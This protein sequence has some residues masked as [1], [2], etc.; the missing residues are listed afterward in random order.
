[1]VSV[2]ILFHGDALLDRLADDGRSGGSCRRKMGHHPANARTTVAP[3]GAVRCRP[4]A[5]HRGRAAPHRHTPNK[6]LAGAI[7]RHHHHA[8][9]RPGPPAGSADEDSWPP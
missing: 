8:G 1:V 7:N 6:R 2:A 4:G 5:R 9:R 3:A